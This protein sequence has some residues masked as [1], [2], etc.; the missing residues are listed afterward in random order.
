MR[1]TLGELQAE[2]NRVR[3]DLAD[4]LEQNRFLQKSIHERNMR[5]DREERKAR[6]AEAALEAI[7]KLYVDGNLQG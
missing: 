6:A 7:K 3:K 5:A 1:K 2:L 4:I